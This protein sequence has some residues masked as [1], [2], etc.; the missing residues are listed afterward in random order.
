MTLLSLHLF[1]PK[2]KFS[3]SIIQML[4]GLRSFAVPF[5]GEEIIAPMGLASQFLSSAFTTPCSLPSLPLGKL[6]CHIP[7]N[8]ASSWLDCSWWLLRNR[9]M[10][11]WGVCLHWDGSFSSRILSSLLSFSH[12]RFFRT[13][14]KIHSVCDFFFFFFGRQFRASDF[15]PHP[16]PH[17]AFMILAMIELSSYDCFRNGH[18]IL[19]A[20]LSSLPR[21]DDATDFSSALVPSSENDCTCIYVCTCVHTPTDIVICARRDTWCP[22]WALLLS[23]LFNLICRIGLPDKIQDA[24]IASYNKELS[25][26]LFV[27]FLI[28]TFYRAACMLICY[29]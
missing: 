14:F 21:G 2:C 27:V 1:Q 11:P 8:S 15:F 17:I 19:P 20:N 4:A 28:F 25:W 18:F 9:L 3:S 23:I 16:H 6:L 10:P 12:N 24:N 13:Q 26:M 7:L 29:I 5:V 22:P